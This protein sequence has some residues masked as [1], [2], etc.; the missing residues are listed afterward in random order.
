MDPTVGLLIYDADCGFCQWVLA[1]GR[2]RLERFPEAVALQQTDP[3]T[4]RL[5]EAQMW[6]AV[7]LI[8]PDGR[9]LSGHRAIAEVLRRQPELRWRL[10]GGALL[11]PP[12]NLLAALG[13]RWVAGHRRLLP[14]AT[15]ACAVPR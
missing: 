5:T 11:L 10:L 9:R 14:G 12:L 2:R 3:A 8:P 1:K 15:Q 6:R 4:V 7:W 13:Y